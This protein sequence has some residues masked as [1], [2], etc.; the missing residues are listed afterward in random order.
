MVKYIEKNTN[1]QIDSILPLKYEREK[2]FN[3][4]FS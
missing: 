4:T 2:K 1:M 3:I